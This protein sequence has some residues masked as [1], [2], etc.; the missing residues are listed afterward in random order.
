MPT[1][2]NSHHHNN[3]TQHTAKPTLALI[4]PLLNEADNLALLLANILALTPQPSEVIFV[5]GGSTDDSVAIIEQFV[6]TQRATAPSS[7]LQW[8]IISAKQAG[9]AMQMNAG[10]EIATASVLLFLHADTRLPVN[11]LAKINKVIHHTHSRDN[12]PEVWGRFDVQLDSHEP[13]LKLVARFINMRSRLSG[14]ATGDQAI[15]ISRTLFNKVGGYPNQPLMEDIELCKRLKPYAKPHCLSSKVTT[16]ARRWQKHG[17]I[18]TIFLMWRL[19]FLYWRGV[20]P[21][22]LKEYYHNHSDKV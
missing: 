9:R 4:I 2:I 10:A 1:Q 17:T 21:S 18:H 20:S 11:A 5:D 22:K 14:I 19:R 15:F 6:H 7:C 16:S 13:L 3:S 8:Q 12:C